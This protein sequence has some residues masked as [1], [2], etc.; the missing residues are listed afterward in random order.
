MSEPIFLKCRTIKCEGKPLLYTNCKHQ[1]SE[2]GDI[3][4]VPDLIDR[5]AAALGEV[6]ARC[7]ALETANRWIPVSERL[8]A[9]NQEILVGNQ[10]TKHIRH[11]ICDEQAFQELQLLKVQTLFRLVKDPG[12]DP[13]I[14]FYATHWQKLPE[15]PGEE[16][17]IK[18]KE[19][20]KQ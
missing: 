15:P 19:T 14:Y 2:C 20:E 12:R 4:T 17:P 8:P 6:Q 10:K 16:K 13:I 1:C 11:A 3:E 18:E 9:I 5:Y 7:K